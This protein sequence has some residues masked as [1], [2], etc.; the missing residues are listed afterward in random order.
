MSALLSLNLEIFVFWHCAIEKDKDIMG[1]TSLQW[2]GV[3]RIAFGLICAINTILQ[4]NSY[5]ITHFL[6]SF[7]ADWAMGQPAWLAQ[8][9]YEMVSLIQSIGTHNVAIATIVINGILA[10]SLITGVGLRVLVWVGIIFNLWLWSTVEGFG[11]PYM[12]GTTDPGTAVIYALSFFFVWVTR[13][14]ENIS[15]YRGTCYQEVSVTGLNF[16]RIIF[17]LIWLFDAFWKWQPHF[18]TNAVTYLEQAQQGQPEWIVSYI[19]LFITFI[20]FIGPVIFG[21][22]IAAAETLIAFSLISG[23][24]LR[25]ML[26][27]GAAYSFILWTTAEGFGG[28]YGLGFTGIKGDILGTA[29]IYVIVFLFLIAAVSSRNES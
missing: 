21:Y 12:Q 7:K 1:S 24:F 16:G 11:G 20:Y 27:F 8:Y 10:L 25:C 22:L 26:L 5:Y 28:P 23:Y 29:N 15:F 18:L 4:A 14:W 3:I 6:S 13:A 2:T 17:G 19:A 9:G